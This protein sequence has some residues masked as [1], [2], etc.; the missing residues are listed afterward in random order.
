MRDEWANF[1]TYLKDQTTFD[2]ELHEMAIDT[3]TDNV[4][5]AVLNALAASTHVSPA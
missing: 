2:P 5:G 4:F 1:R 3:C